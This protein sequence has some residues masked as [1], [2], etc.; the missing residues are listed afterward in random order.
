[1]SGEADADAGYGRALIP[2]LAGALYMHTPIVY[3]VD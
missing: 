3:P 1:M 2:V